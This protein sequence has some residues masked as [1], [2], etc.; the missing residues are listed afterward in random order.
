MITI[1]IP[2]DLW[3]FLNVNK[4]RG[5]SFGDVL[6]RLLN[7]GKLLKDKKEENGN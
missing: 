6:R 1:Q 3:K 7:E 4:R 5:E 2:D